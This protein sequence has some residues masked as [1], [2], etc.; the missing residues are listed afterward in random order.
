MKKEAEDAL[1][2]QN[3]RRFRTIVILVSG[4]LLVLFA[5]V[6][7]NRFGYEQ[8]TTPYGE[9]VAIRIDKLTGRAC[10]MS[11]PENLTSEQLMRDVGYDRCV[12][13]RIA[14]AQ[15]RAAETGA[16]DGSQ[17]DNRH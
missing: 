9:E 2:G 8:I 11:A 16:A 17:I 13:R 7:L 10:V 14:T 1:L 15:P 4:M 5:V 12:G 6:W 3:P